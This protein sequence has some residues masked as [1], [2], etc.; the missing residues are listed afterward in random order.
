MEAGPRGRVV[1]AAARDHGAEVVW[2]E[3]RRRPRGRAP[4]PLGRGAGGV[5][6]LADHLDHRLAGVGLGARKDLRRKEEAKREHKD[7]NERKR[8]IHA[9]LIIK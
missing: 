2:T 1:L 6:N 7:E 8:N 3:R 5:G 9:P 4:G